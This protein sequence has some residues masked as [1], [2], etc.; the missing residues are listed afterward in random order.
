MVVRSHR[1]PC[2]DSYT[3]PCSTAEGFWET[4][5]GHLYNSVISS[6]LM[7]RS[8]TFVP[9][10]GK[11]WSSRRESGS[12]TKLHCSGLWDGTKQTLFG[13]WPVRGTV[14][15]K[16]CLVVLACCFLCDA[17]MNS[18]ALEC[19]EASIKGPATSFMTTLAQQANLWSPSRE[20]MSASWSSGHTTGLKNTET[21]LLTCKENIS[22]WALCIV[23]VSLV[24]RQRS[25]SSEFHH[26]GMRRVL[27]LLS[28]TVC[29]AVQ[30]KHKHPKTFHCRV[31]LLLDF[32]HGIFCVNHC[33]LP[34]IWHI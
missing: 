20:Q 28:Q 24:D 3:L 11:S 13:S 9:V 17:I 29:L 4:L 26:E 19:W 21:H 12:W 34:L 33:A 14:Q 30:K 27:H 5:P 32:R 8:L 7:F 6:Y 15:C 18:T 31:L 25:L 10:L 23:N 22:C 16:S 2:L 1:S